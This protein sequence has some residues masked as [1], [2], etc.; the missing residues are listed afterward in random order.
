V[1]SKSAAA[2]SAGV[3]LVLTLSGCTDKKN[4]LDA[5]AK[6]VCDAVQ[7][8]AQ[9][10]R[11]AN[12]AMQ[13]VTSDSSSKP[14]QIRQ[15]DSKAF[16]D[17]SEAYQAI[18]AAV[19]QAGPPPVNG[20]D[21][22]QQDAVQALK[23]TARSYADLKKQ[24]DGLNTK[25]QS[26]FADGLHGVA[27]RLSKTITSGDQALKQLEQGDAGKAMGKQ[28]SCKTAAATSS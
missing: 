13:Q 5:W 27:A 22:R 19:N 28:A 2:L 26:K 15:S 4:G 12:T 16:A 25:D 24:V 17:M 11:S 8:Q 21:H 10:I 14:E 23:G 3:V 20:G 18:G 9:K 6:T 7:P 1:N